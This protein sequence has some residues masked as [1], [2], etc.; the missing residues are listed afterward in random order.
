[1]TTQ[2]VTAQ[3]PTTVANYIAAE[4][5]AGILDGRYPFGSR[6][7]QQALA[8]QLG[9]SIIP[10]REALRRLDAEGLVKIY[11]RKGAFVAEF[12]FRELREIHL[13]RER[14][15]A[16][17][18]ELAI[19]KLTEEN[20]AELQSANDRLAGMTKKDQSA[21]WDELNREWHL[22]LYSYADAPFLQQTIAMLWERTTLYRT[23]NSVRTGH[24]GQ[25]AQEHAALLAC[26]ATGDV[27]GAIEQLQVHIRRS[28]DD[29][30]AAGII[31]D[32][33]L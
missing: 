11:P 12:P 29:V 32:K 26:C 25:S 27:A 8:D 7:D 9:A 10:L 21:S 19:G 28:L 22:K 18:L 16:L 30:V 6:I 15:E 14:L 33:M 4:I 1:V 17:A 23:V 13:I 5:R 24:R 31:D 2:G 20:I 3:G